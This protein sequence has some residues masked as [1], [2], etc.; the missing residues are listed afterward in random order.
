ML[1]VNYLNN[2]YLQIKNMNKK[3]TLLIIFFLLIGCFLGMFI[4][5]I[6]E[7]SQSG[8]S[9]TIE[10]QGEENKEEVNCDEPQDGVISCPLPEEIYQIDGTIIQLGD[11]FL[12]IEPIEAIEEGESLTYSG[13]LPL[14]GEELERQ[15]LTLNV[16]KET[17]ILQIKQSDLVG[18]EISSESSEELIVSFKD[19]KIGDHI[20]TIVDERIEG[21]DK[22]IAKE[23]QIIKTDLIF[24]QQ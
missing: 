20:L 23:I 16:S 19:L 13:Q 7:N 11:N 5:K 10:N 6:I 9:N 4:E 2:K 21:Q 14:E 8:L 24:P 3:I 1:K 22:F 18:L 12:I 15:S 17:K